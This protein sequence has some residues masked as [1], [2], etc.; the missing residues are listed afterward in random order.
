M[1]IRNRDFQKIV[2]FLL[3]PAFVSALIILPSFDPLAI[4]PE[5]LVFIIFLEIVCR[6]QQTPQQ[7]VCAASHFK[8]LPRGPPTF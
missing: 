2:I 8:I 6:I 7:R 1:L 4:L 3:V 5:L